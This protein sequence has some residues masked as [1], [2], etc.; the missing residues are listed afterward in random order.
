MFVCLCAL[1]AISTDADNGWR[2]EGAVD[3][4]PIFAERS[5]WL[6]ERK[7]ERERAGRGWAFSQ[8][9]CECRWQPGISM[10]TKHTV[11]SWS[12]HI[13]AFLVDKI[14][15]IRS[16][17]TT[18]FKVTKDI[19]LELEQTVGLLAHLR[20]KEREREKKKEKAKLDG[21]SELLLVMGAIS[22]S[23]V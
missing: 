18:K 14:Y 16:I 2:W 20:E 15:C 12:L 3:T 1:L 11:K 8:V 5:V 22:L 13:V 21:R 19:R 4:W 17:H 10:F 23:R 7:R 9:D 6:P